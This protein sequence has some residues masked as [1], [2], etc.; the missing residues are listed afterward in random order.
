LAFLLLAWMTRGYLSGAAVWPLLGVVG[1]MLVAEHVLAHRIDLA[2]FR[3]NAWLGF[4]VF[5][6]VWAGI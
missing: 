2:F 5:E 4:V 6:L 1:G 3:I